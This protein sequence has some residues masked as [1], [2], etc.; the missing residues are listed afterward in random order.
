MNEFY[1][2]VVEHQIKMKSKI[3]GSGFHSSRADF[4]WELLKCNDGSGGAGR[5]RIF[6]LHNQRARSRHYFPHVYVCG[7]P[8]LGKST[9]ACIHTLSLSPFAWRNTPLAAYRKYKIQVQFSLMWREQGG[10]WLFHV[11]F[12]KREMYFATERGSDQHNFASRFSLTLALHAR[13]I[14][15]HTGRL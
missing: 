5:S 3:Q 12:I 9:H 2:F 8:T 4:W 7:A 14:H 6:C 1:H 10:G 15:T 13:H 11:C